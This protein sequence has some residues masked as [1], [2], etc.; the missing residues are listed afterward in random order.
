MTW[1]PWLCSRKWI[2]LICVGHLDLLFVLWR[3]IFWDPNVDSAVS[4]DGLRRSSV[5]GL[6]F[7]VNSFQFWFIYQTF[8]FHDVRISLILVL[9]SR[10][11]YLFRLPCFFHSAAMCSSQPLHNT[12]K[13]HIPTLI[14]KISAMQISLRI[15]KQMTLPLPCGWCHSRCEQRCI[16]LDCQCQRYLVQKRVIHLH[17]SGV[18][19]N[20]LAGCLPRYVY[21]PFYNN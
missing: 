14:L 10:S 11:S 4:L 3:W 20:Y 15:I 5:L 9:L 21:G 6:F 2:F 7:S 16:D 18:G 13:Y 12:W 8:D 17:S 19:L 1:F